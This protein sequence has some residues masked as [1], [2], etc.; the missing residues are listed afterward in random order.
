MLYDISGSGELDWMDVEL[1]CV[2]DDIVDVIVDDA[3][4]CEMDLASCGL[5]V[6]ERCKVVDSFAGCDGGYEN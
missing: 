5:F 6:V 3:N 2:V 1:L 4:D